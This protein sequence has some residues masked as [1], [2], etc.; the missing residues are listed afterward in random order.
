MDVTCHGYLVHTVIFDQ[1]LLGSKR[2]K[3]VHTIK[4]SANAH[5]CDVRQQFFYY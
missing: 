4:P 3:P 2:C 1:S 5:T